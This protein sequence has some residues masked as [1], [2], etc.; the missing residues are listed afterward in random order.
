MQNRMMRLPTLFRSLFTQDA[1]ALNDATHDD[2]HAPNGE[3]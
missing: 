1:T 3:I 2:G